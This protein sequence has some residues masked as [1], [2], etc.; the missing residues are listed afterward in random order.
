MR[1]PEL[2]FLR[3]GRVNRRGVAGEIQAPTKEASLQDEARPLHLVSRGLLTVES[4]IVQTPE[5]LSVLIPADVAQRYHLDTGV[6]VELNP[7]EEGIFFRP[8]GVEAWFSVEWERALEAVLE[9]Y[10]P[11]LEAIN[12]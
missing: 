6:K 4:E 5:G 8:V 3:S 11:A 9:R 10:K 7:V 1:P 12:E 2:L